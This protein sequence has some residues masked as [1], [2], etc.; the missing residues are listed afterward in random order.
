MYKRQFPEEDESAG[1]CVA[2]ATAYDSKVA[3]GDETPMQTM[4]TR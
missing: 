1:E 4:L 3:D 2:K